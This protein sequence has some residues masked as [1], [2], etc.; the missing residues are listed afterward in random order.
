MGYTGILSFFFIYSGLRIGRT[1]YYFVR[2]DIFLGIYLTWF[3]IKVNKE[4][5]I[6]FNWYKVEYIV[7]KGFILNRSNTIH[8]LLY[9]QGVKS[10]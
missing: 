4:Y 9:I 10:P 7:G 3:C 6:W 5:L 2:L 1:K 8:T